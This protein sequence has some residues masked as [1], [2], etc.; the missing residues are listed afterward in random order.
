M[1][2][3]ARHFD[4]GEDT[5]KYEVEVPDES[6]DAAEAAPGAAAQQQQPSTALERPFGKDY[7]IRFQSG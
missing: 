1:D 4:E 3:F 5:S 2:G 6:G 7:A